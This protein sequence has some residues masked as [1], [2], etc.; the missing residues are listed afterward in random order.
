MGGFDVRI[1]RACH[2]CSRREVGFEVGQIDMPS[3]HNIRA[4]HCL[5]SASKLPEGLW[6][7]KL[8]GARQSLPKA[9]VRAVCEVL[10][11]LRQQRPGNVPE[12]IRP[13]ID[14]RQSNSSCTQ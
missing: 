1:N 2:P 5:L 11:S 12:P 4:N 14:N 10:F 7:V 3:M 9:T 13:T 8:P 6:S